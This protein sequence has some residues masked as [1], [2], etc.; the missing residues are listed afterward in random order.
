MNTDPSYGL[1]M[2]EDP[3]NMTQTERFYK[4][5]INKV[6]IATKNHFIANGVSEKVHDKLKKVKTTGT[7]YFLSFC[8]LHRIAIII[9][10]HLINR[11]YCH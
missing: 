8:I 11:F 1:N 10:W 4:N 5:V 6:M 9:I 7:A 2:K 3:V